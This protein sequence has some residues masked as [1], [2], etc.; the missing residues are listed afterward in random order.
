MHLHKD[1]NQFGHKLSRWSLI[2]PFDPA[3]LHRELVIP[4]PDLKP[5]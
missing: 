5:R 3:N 2:R 1:G 4:T